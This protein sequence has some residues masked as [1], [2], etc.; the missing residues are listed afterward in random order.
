MSRQCNRVSQIMGVFMVG[1]LIFTNSVVA[2]TAEGDPIKVSAS[3]ACAENAG[4]TA[5][6]VFDGSGLDA[7]ADPPT[8]TSNPWGTTWQSG[9]WD[10][11]QQGK[12]WVRAEFAASH[13]LKSLRIWN[14]N[15]K[16]WTAAGVKELEI[17]VSEN[18]KD[19]TA[20]LK[21]NLEQAPGNDKYT[22]QL[23]TLDKPVTARFV[24]LVAG[25]N[26]GSTEFGLSEVQFFSSAK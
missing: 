15:E 18:D 14:Y 24:K 13:E 2:D 11:D 23:I 19:Y 21:V 26:H 16:D 22:G 5:A 20:A 9:G 6:K 3:T 17:L 8:H 10:V 25:S 7:S 1:G 4:R 12:P